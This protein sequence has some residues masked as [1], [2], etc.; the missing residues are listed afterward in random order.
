MDLAYEIALERSMLKPKTKQKINQAS[1]IFLWLQAL[2]Y[3]QISLETKQ[4]LW[5][6]LID[7]A[8]IVGKTDAP[9]LNNPGKAPIIIGGG[10]IINNY[11]TSYAGVAFQNLDI[12]ATEIADSFSIT[13]GKGC[14]WIYTAYKGTT[15]SRSGIIQATWLAD[16]TQ[17]RFQHLT[18][19]AI[20]TVD[21]GFNVDFS[22]GN[23]RLLAVPVSPD[24]TVEGTRF[25]HY[26]IGS[27][28]GSPS[29][30]TG[31]VSTF[32]ELT[33]VPSDYTGQAGK[34]VAVRSDE[35]G[36]EF[37]DP[38]SGGP[39]TYNLSSPST[40]AVGGLPAGTSLTGR[41]WQSIIEELLV[42]YLAPVFSSFA[43]GGTAIIEVGATLGG[44]KTFTW[45][46]TNPTNVAVNSIAIRDMVTSA[47]IA[48]GLANDGSEVVNTGALINTTPTTRTWR[49]EGTNTVAGSFVS[50]TDSISSI[51]PYFYGKVASGG[52]APGVS[53]PAANQ[54]LINGGT[55]VVASS[56]ATITINFNSTSDDY[57]WF[58]IPTTSTS[59]TVWF[60]D[61]LNNGTIG[62]SV[63]PG[64]NLF[65]AFASVTIDSPSSLWTGVS[66]KIYISNYQSASAVNME[67]RNS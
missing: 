13:A 19:V 36:L 64:G 4:R 66:Y 32:V 12:D 10:N 29:S 52:A 43:V 53:R 21:I 41:S 2:S 46:T 38:S 6:C 26:N 8:G 40:V 33:D 31:G 63:S 27:T 44:S 34:L 42:D 11:Y 60:V 47:L 49:A 14:M 61:A 22:G 17:I 15:N 20:G 39:D 18:T 54:A 37:I 25:V 3:P 23:I 5:Y 7:I 45:G 16:G 24:W 62:G 35:L 30:G 50:S 48:S 56:G 67:L 28:P 1:K 55:K 57:I 59:K 58:A 65:P 51:Y 9:I